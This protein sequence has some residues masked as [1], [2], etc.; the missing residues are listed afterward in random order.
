MSSKI[1]RICLELWLDV[2]LP[3]RLAAWIQSEFGPQAVSI[4]EI[5]LGDAPDREIFLL[6][7][8]ESA[9]VLT[10]ILSKHPDFAALLQDLGPPPAIIWLRCGNVSN[11]TLMRLLSREFPPALERIR[12]GE[13]LVEIGS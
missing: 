6:A 8:R 2:Q 1:P 10:A 12:T 9:I 5:G 4:L 13:N 3:R 7:R 11:V